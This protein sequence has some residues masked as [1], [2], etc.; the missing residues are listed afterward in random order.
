MQANETAQ[1]AR[2][3]LLN[4][5]ASPMRDELES[6]IDLVLNREK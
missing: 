3:A 6:L 5:P 4:V 2:T 1:R